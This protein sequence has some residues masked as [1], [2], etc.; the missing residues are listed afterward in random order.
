MQMHLQ[1]SM[2]SMD[3]VSMEMSPTSSLWHSYLEL[4]EHKVYYSLSATLVIAV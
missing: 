3:T 4:G 1:A 2:C